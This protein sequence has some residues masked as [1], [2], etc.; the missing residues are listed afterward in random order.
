MKEIKKITLYKKLLSIAVILLTILVFW[1]CKD[2]VEEIRLDRRLEGKDLVLITHKNPV[3]SEDYTNEE[4]SA[5]EYDVTKEEYYIPGQSIELSVWLEAK[6]LKIEVEKEGTP[7]ILATLDSFTESGGGYS[8]TWTTDVET[9]GI[10]KG[11]SLSYVFYIFYDDKGED[12]FPYS[13]E[14]K[15]TFR[16]HHKSTEETSI[17]S[18]KSGIGEMISI[19]F[20]GPVSGFG[21]DDLFGTFVE[22]D[23]VNDLVTLSEQEAN[24]DFTHADDFSVS[25]WVNTAAGN[26]DPSMIGDK[27]WGSGGNKGFVMSFLGSDWKVNIGDGNGNRA[28]ANGAI[29]NDG[30]WHHIATT[31]DRSGLMTLYQDGMKISDA[32][33]TAVGDMDSSLPI[34]IGQDGTGSYGDW[35]L[36]KIGGIVISNYVLSSDEVLIQS[37]MSSGVLLRTAN[38]VEILDVVDSGV[39][40]VVEEGRVTRDF[41]NGPFSTI[42]DNGLLD[43]RYDGDYSISFWVNTTSTDSDPVMIGDQ[44]WNS[45]GNIGLTIAFRGDNWRVAVSDGTT[46]ADASTSDLGLPFNDGQWHLLATTFDRN[47]DM[48]MYQDGELV[49]SASMTAVGNTNSGNPLR[50]AQDGP[51]TYPQFFEGKIAN[52]VIFDYVLAPEEIGKLFIE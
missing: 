11:T 19:G 25:F 43:F 49:A 12:G 13:S 20:S 35:F 50:L 2:D 31:F 38:N 3:T 36:G 22:L 46:K 8:G 40:P 21:N 16:I 15:T 1:R 30:L 10:L 52:P 9:L 5:I 18:L 48:K 32:D 14:N 37:Q 29:I 44:D 23:G 39:S 28:D 6:P 24:L 17:A 45:S 42:Q 33:I 4:L 41:T 47:G 26:S 7:A 27:D 51:N 34:N